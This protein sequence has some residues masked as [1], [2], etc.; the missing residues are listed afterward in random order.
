MT[1]G[2]ILEGRRRTYAGGVTCRDGIWR[3]EVLRKVLRAMDVR[4]CPWM[5]MDE[6]VG[7]RQMD[8]LDGWRASTGLPQW[9]CVGR[10]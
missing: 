5:S 1:C 8:P 4:G 6:D 10:T 2:K 9:F 7:R 3:A